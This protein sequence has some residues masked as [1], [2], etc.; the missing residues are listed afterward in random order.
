MEALIAAL[1]DEVVRELLEAAVHVI[2]AS[3]QPGAQH[4]TP[5]PHPTAAL[6]ALLSLC[7]HTVIVAKSREEAEAQFAAVKASHQAADAVINKA[8]GG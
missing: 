5:C 6:A 3:S 8:K 1:P 2:Y 4:P 7:G